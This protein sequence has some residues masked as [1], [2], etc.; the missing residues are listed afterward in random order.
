MKDGRLLH[1]TASV[2]SPEER[3]QGFGNSVTANAIPLNLQTP[4]IQQYNATFERE[5]IHDGTLRLSYL[6]THMGGLIAGK[7]LDELA[8][9]NM[10]FGTTQG[11][12]VTICDPTQGDCAYSP[13]D[14]ARLPFPLIGEFLLTYG[15]FGHGNSNSFQTEFTRRYKTGL[16]LDVSYTYL[17]QKTSAL[18]TANSSL[19][20]IA[21]N[22]FTPNSDYGTDGYVSKHRF[23]AYGIYDLP[24]GR[25][26][27]IGNSFNKVTNAI[28]GRMANYLQHVCEVRT[29][30]YPILGL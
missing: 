22:P 16:M 19:G 28:A 23:I 24:V 3:R 17:D 9:N 2:L 4:R 25:N 18:D 13:Q 20:G 10:P 27:R 30:L 8:P 26:H 6:G 5:I 29:R 1:R 7:D 11:D 12:G 21:Y 14:L 15:N